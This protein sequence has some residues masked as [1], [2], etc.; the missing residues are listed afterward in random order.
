MN[1]AGAKVVKN[2]SILM[3]SQ[4]ITWILS[5]L[6]TIFLP[7][8]LGA[9]VTGEFVLANS[10]WAIMGML[11]GF[12]TDT[13]LTKEIARHPERT[14]ELVGTAFSIRIVLFLLMCGL[15]ALYI[16]LTS[17]PASTVHL[18]WIIGISSLIT[19]IG[20]ACQSALQG[21]EY[22]HY[23]S[24]AGIL[25]KAVNT[26]LA[27]VVVFLGLSVYSIG[28]V[29]IISAVVS[30][31]LLLLFLRRY[32]KIYVQVHVAPAIEMIKSSIP[33]LLSGMGLILYGQIDV[34]IISSMINAREVGWYGITTQL[35]G[36]LL[37]IPVVFTTAIFPALTRAYSNQSSSLSLLIRK[38]FDLML[39][40]SI[41]IGLGIL[42]IADP[43]IILLYGPAFAQSGPILSIMGIV[44]IFMYLNILV[45]Q[46]LISTDRQ[47]IWTIIMFFATIVT[48]PL[49]LLLV[50]WSQSS[51]G[52]GALGGAISFV[53]TE[54]GMCIAGIYLLPKG[55]LGWSNL[56]SGILIIGAG[57]GMAIATWYCRELFIVIPIFVGA[58]TYIC[59]IAILRVFPKEDIAMLK[60]A[61]QDT[62]RK[63][64]RRA[65]KPV[66]D[67]SINY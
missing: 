54:F 32:F 67:P 8:Y 58:L 30:T 17:C 37:F 66:V 12:G 48:V 19:Q 25:S 47:N 63:V 43:L 59:L 57:I 56:R 50:P 16:Q 36:T 53:I 28:F 44:V 26:I 14:S 49:D 65:P 55:S 31:T 1:G 60:K 22:M 33:Y 24:I 40:L 23:T 62:L 34:L 21:L 35:T 3:T 39:M 7:R 9:A 6:L 13:L 4:L 2:A 41:P 42:V 29:T 18:I 61:V 10:I 52:N 11:I 20:L 45:G 27:L 46:F 15:V 38:S 51:F 5:L 64:R